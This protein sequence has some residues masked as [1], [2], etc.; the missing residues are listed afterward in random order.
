[1]PLFEG[2][3]HLSKA[4]PKALHEGVMTR[5]ANGGGALGR[6]YLNLAGSVSSLVFRFRRRKRHAA[7]E[8]KTVLSQF[9]R[10]PFGWILD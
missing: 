2:D 4:T 5:L 10:D 9:S 8:F 3:K 6:L 1:M 7:A